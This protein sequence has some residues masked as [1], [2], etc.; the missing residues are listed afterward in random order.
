MEHY[1]RVN[2]TPDNS[3]ELFSMMFEDG[4]A[5]SFRHDI[6]EPESYIRSLAP[7]SQPAARAWR[8]GLR[9]SAA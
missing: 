7:A 8:G 9:G 3:V 4:K 6:R 5:A 2:D 1:R